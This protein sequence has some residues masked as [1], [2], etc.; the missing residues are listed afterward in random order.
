MALKPFSKK[1][2]L[3]FHSTAN[4]VQTSNYWVFMKSINYEPFTYHIFMETIENMFYMTEYNSKKIMTPS[5][6]PGVEK[7]W[8]EFNHSVAGRGT[9]GI[10][11]RNIYSYISIFLKL[12]NQAHCPKQ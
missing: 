6:C 10:G 4:R 7:V 5:T 11:H 1:W 8:E 9:W 3:F 2:I 12:K